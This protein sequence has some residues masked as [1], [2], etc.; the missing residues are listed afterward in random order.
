MMRR[1]QPLA[2]MT[3]MLE[4]GYTHFQQTRFGM[5]SQPTTLQHSS[6]V[7]LPYLCDKVDHYTP[8]VA[9]PQHHHYLMPQTLHT[10]QGLDC[11]R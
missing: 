4:A 8:N 1:Q 6:E 7:E 5:N 3:K 10:C 2:L 9:A 11:F